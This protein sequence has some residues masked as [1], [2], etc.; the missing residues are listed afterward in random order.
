M[1]YAWYIVAMTAVYMVTVIA[2]FLAKNPL[3]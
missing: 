1:R 3:R 2:L